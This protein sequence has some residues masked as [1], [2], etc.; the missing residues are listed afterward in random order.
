MHTYKRCIDFTCLNIAVAVGRIM[1]IILEHNQ[2][3]KRQTSF[4]NQGQFNKRGR[5]Q[6]RGNGGFGKFGGKR[7][8][9]GAGPNTHKWA[10]RTGAPSPEKGK[11]PLSDRLGPPMEVKKSEGSGKEGN[12]DSS[13]RVLNGVQ[14][15]D[16]MGAETK[17]NNG[18][19]GRRHKPIE[20]PKSSPSQVN[21]PLMNM[22]PPAAVK[23]G[24][25]QDHSQV[26][27]SSSS[28]VVSACYASPSS[29]EAYRD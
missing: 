10:T 14:K 9:G 28:V 21:L 12:D 20:A 19:V 15:E 29:G 13:N 7:G 6:G 17:E 25:S 16:N 23:P 5:N 1:H 8:Q 22:P 26:P 24:H 3:P 27:V 18:S 11:P 4:N 2:N